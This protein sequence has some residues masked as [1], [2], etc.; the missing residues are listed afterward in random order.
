[1]ENEAPETQRASSE[2]EGKGIFQEIDKHLL[3][4]SDAAAALVDAE[5]YSEARLTDAAL[6]GLTRLRS[7]VGA[8]AGHRTSYAADPIFSSLL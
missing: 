5:T 3:I 7:L 6:E 8:N 1:M 4:V 2:P